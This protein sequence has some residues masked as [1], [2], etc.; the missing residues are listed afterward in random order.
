MHM[1]QALSNTTT[2]EAITQIKNHRTRQ[3]LEQKKGMVE[4]WK[5]RRTDLRMWSRSKKT[6][7]I[8]QNQ[9]TIR[10]ESFM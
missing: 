1:L 9:K 8:S 7:K 3:I 4:T 10:P 5:A 6:Q 2:P